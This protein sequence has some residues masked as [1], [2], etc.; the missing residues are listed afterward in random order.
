VQCKNKKPKGEFNMWLASQKY[1]RKH[2]TSR[3]D[4]CIA[5]NKRMEEEIKKSNAAHVVKNGGQR[6]TES[7]TEY[8]KGPRE[9]SCDV[10]NAHSSSTSQSTYK[11]KIADQ[12][13]SKTENGLTNSQAKSANRDT[14]K[15]NTKYNYTCPCCSARIPSTLRTGNV[16]VK[17]VDANNHALCPTISS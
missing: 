10:N 15:T 1:Q 17:H 16:M 3:C 9:Q 7:Q 8:T 4:A 6:T 12:M 13:H 14:T 5:D 11:R 2:H